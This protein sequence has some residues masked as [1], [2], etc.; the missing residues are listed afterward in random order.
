MTRGAAAPVISVRGLTKDYGG[1]RGVFGVN[2]EV[3]PGEVLGFLGPNGAGKTV[4]MRHL[5]GFVRP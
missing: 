3:A 1:G 4:T 5:M 2:L